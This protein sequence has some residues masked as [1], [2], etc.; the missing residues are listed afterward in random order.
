[1]VHLHPTGHGIEGHVISNLGSGCVQS[2]HFSGV[3]LT[4]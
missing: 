2:I 4:P 3:N 1:M